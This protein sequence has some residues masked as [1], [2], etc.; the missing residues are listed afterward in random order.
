M[1]NPEAYT[2]AALFLPRLLGLIYF[3]AIGAFLF[4]IKGL[5]GKNG[6]LPVKDYL[7]YFRLHSSRKIYFYIP[8]LFWFNASDRALMGLTF[9]GTFL[10]LLLMLG[11]Y[12][13]VLLGL[14]FIIYL[15]IVSV[16][17]D[18]LSFGWESFL[19][20]ITF[21]TFWVSLTP[22][23]NLVMWINLNFLLFRFYIQ[24]GAVKLQ[25]GDVAWR[26][27]TGAAFHYQSQPLPNTWSWYVY[28]WPLM[29]H[30]MSTLF[31]FFVELIVPFGLFLSDDIRAIAGILFISLQIAF[32]LTGNFSFLNHLTAVFCIIAF[33]NRMLSFFYEAT[34]LPQAEGLSNDILNVIGS[35]FLILQG[36]RL[37]HHFQY[38]NHLLAKCLAWFSPFHLIN[39]Y[40]LFAIMTKERYEIIVEGSED[41]IK[42][43][44]YLC[45]FKPSEITRRPRRISPF[46]PRL[47]WQMWFLPFD[48]FESATWFHQFLS[49]LLKGTPEVLKLIRHNPFS[50]H[51]P[52]YIRAL[53]YDYRFSSVNQ[54]KELEWWWQREYIGPFSP[55][56]TLKEKEN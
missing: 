34:P 45:W 41:G 8:S 56:M 26:N 55:V 33:D 28:K 19:L 10:S 39:R 40:G 24:A 2:T 11:F 37:W 29:I 47:D 12:P 23:P 46:Q 52:K 16:G 17:Q 42:W 49:H 44:E 43:E 38:N 4:Q 5:L 54:K 1:W 35:L 22:I 21:Y 6:I 50:K 9:F 14:L 31:M 36:L 13:S 7:N 48:D 3:F 15:S 32:W 20:E 53:M 27:L 30:K 25:S 51:P 18:F